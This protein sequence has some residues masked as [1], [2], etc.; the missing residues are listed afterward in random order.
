LFNQYPP[1]QLETIAGHYGPDAETRYD[2]SNPPTHLFWCFRV[3]EGIQSGKAITT[4]DVETERVP[5]TDD[6]F[7]K[8]LESINEL[9]S[10][11]APKEAMKKYGALRSDLQ[12][13][14]IIEKCKEAEEQTPGTIWS[15]AGID[16]DKR[17]RRRIYGKQILE[18]C[19]LYVMLKREPNRQ[20]S[21]SIFS[22]MP[23][24]TEEHIERMEW[25]VPAAPRKEMR[26]L[27]QCLHCAVGKKKVD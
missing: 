22:S 7:R 5:S 1:I 12:R 23:T 13:L 21:M 16:T 17:T 10:Y 18:T 25:D 27:G 4:R 20:D 14:R 11:K 9:G 8:M 26:E 3:R 19:A 24:Y 6:R 15:V 2:P